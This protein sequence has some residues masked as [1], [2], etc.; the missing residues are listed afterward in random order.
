MT[1]CE[2]IAAHNSQS[3]TSS[4]GAEVAD[5]MLAIPLDEYLELPDFLRHKAV[6]LRTPPERYHIRAGDLAEYATGWKDS[7]ES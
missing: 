5:V 2:W 3:G 6:K 7:N 4:I 1:L